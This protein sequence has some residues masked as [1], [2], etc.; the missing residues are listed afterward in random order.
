MASS[1]EK[2]NTH[3]QRKK[4]VMN[5]ELYDDYSILTEPGWQA[6]EQSWSSSTTLQYVKLAFSDRM[7]P[8]ECHAKNIET[9]NASW[10]DLIDIEVKWRFVTILRAISNSDRYT[11]NIIP[12]SIVS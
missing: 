6:A 1:E 11:Q 5:M 12:V 8:R 10:C 4:K 7:W 9:N 3:R 2:K